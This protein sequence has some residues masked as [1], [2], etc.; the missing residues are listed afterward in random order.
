M[1]ANWALSCFS[2][3]L[4]PFV[5]AAKLGSFLLLS[6]VCR[7]RDQKEVIISQL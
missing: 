3:G 5:V 1:D 7:R 6:W 4:D 2:H